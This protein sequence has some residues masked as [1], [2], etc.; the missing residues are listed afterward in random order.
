MY[1][2]IKISQTKIC[3]IPMEKWTWHMSKQF[4]KENNIKEKLIF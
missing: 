3:K 1:K 2:P 4:K